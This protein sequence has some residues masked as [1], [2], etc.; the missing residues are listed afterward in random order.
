MPRQKRYEPKNK[1]ELR[2]HPRGWLNLAGIE[3][4]GIIEE[5]DTLIVVQAVTCL[6][7][8]PICPKCE[9]N[10][11]VTKW[12][13]RPRNI[14]DVEGGGKLVLIVL[15]RQR[16]DCKRCDKTF[17]P[18]LPF[19]ERCRIRRTSRLTVKTERLANER[20]TTSSVAVATGLSRRTVQSIASRTAKE[21]TTPQDVFRQAAEAEEASW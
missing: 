3:V 7:G 20:Q 19:L 21:R 12:D 10:D 4:E 17:S 6:E 5:T 11:E 2:P 15:R 1:S 16:Y 14:R 9:L 18:P 13:F 8:M